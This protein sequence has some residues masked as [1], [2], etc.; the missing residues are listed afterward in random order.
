MT[1]EKLLGNI[2]YQ[3]ICYGGYRTKTRDNEPSIAE[4]KEDMKI[5]SA[6]NIKIIRTIIISCVYISSSI[7]IINADIITYEISVRR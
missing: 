4:L 2:N 1:A 3:A 5:L 7:C 6:M